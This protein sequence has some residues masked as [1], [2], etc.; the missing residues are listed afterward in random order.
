M[1]F[2]ETIRNIVYLRYSLTLYRHSAASTS[3]RITKGLISLRVSRIADEKYWFCHPR[4]SQHAALP[5]RNIIKFSVLYIFLSSKRLYG[6][7]TYDKNHPSI[8]IYAMLRCTIHGAAFA[9]T[10]LY[11]GLSDHVSACMAFCSARCCTSGEY[12]PVFDL[13]A[14]IC[15]CDPVRNKNAYHLAAR[16]ERDGGREDEMENDAFAASL[17]A[18]LPFRRL[19]L[20]A[21]AVHKATR[22]VARNQQPSLSRWQIVERVRSCLSYVHTYLHACMDLCRVSLHALCALSLLFFFLSLSLSLSLSLTYFL[23]RVNDFFSPS[24]VTM[25]A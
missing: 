8:L 23:I 10:K 25:R 14:T 18:M 5:L 19:F 24:Y 20:L 6:V 9:A 12:A 15:T 4:D 1:Y 7:S 11:G 3:C 16:R 21:F 17:P 2:P 22:E 13:T